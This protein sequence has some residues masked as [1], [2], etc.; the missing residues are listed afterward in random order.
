MEGVAR[1]RQHLYARMPIYVV[2]RHFSQQRYSNRSAKG[3]V[4][5]IRM[6][7]PKDTYCSLKLRFGGSNLMGEPRTV[8]VPSSSW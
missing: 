4:L 1:Y 7:S 6:N 3:K 5:D 2:D 8:M